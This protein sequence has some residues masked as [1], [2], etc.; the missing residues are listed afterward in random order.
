MDLQGDFEFLEFNVGKSKNDYS[1]TKIEIFGDNVEHTNEIVRE[2]LRLG[3]VLPET[4]E[5]EYEQAPGDMMLPD[6]FYCTTNHETSVYLDGEWVLVENQM[7]D[8][9]IVVVPGNSRAFCKPIGMV[10]EGDLIVVG[11]KGIRVKSFFRSITPV[12]GI[13]IITT[14]SRVSPFS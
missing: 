11:D 6:A 1:T 5:V 9:H 4:P 8:K 7:M 2:V 10:K 12:H 13:P 14:S 3:A